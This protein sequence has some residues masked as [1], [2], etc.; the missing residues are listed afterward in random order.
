[1]LIS[2]DDIQ[3]GKTAAMWAAENGHTEVVALLAEAKAD[4]DYQGPV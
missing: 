4:L 3:N 1:M 2:C